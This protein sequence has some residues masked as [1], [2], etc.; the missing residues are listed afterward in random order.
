MSNLIQSFLGNA[1]QKM[2][3]K[4]SLLE[5]GIIKNLLIQLFIK[6]Y[7][8]DMSDYPRMSCHEYKHFNDFF[9]RE[10]HSN[11]RVIDASENGLISPVDGKVIEF[12]RIDEGKLIQIKGMEYE[13]FGLLDNNE[14]LARNYEKGA[15]ISIYLAPFNYHRVHAP[16]KGRLK[17]A[18]MVPGEMNRVDL[19]ALSDI[20]NLYTKNQRLIAEF[21]DSRSDCILI[22]IA[23]RNVASMTYKN[24]IKDFSKGDEVGRFNL[25]STV[26]VL[27]PNDIETKWN[28]RVSSGNDVK[29]GE[30]IALLSKIK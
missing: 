5:A 15:F 8:I 1:L 7:K 28:Q 18:T 23:A 29:V 22:M 3:L 19:K 21:N 30:K 25:G 14:M 11:K 27:L 2:V 13:L 26:V 4:V 16:L 20:E 6:N 24:Q 10:I 17:Q 9:T 12:G